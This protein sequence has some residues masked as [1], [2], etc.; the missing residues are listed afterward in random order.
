MRLPTDLCHL[1]LTNKSDKTNSHILSKFISTKFMEG[2]G[3]QRRGYQLDTE[4]VLNNKSKIIQ[5]SVK[6]DY[7]L[8]AEC[9]AYFGLIENI[10][11]RTF[12][13]LE[14]G[15]AEGKILKDTVKDFLDLLYC[16]NS[17]PIIIRLFVYSLFWR[18][19]ISNDSLFEDYQLKDTFE[20]EVRTSLLQYKAR[21]KDEL[22]GLT[23]SDHAIQIFP[24]TIM[25]AKSFLDTTS[26]ILFAP[27]SY[28]PYCLIVDRFSFMLFRRHDD[29]KVDFIR[30]FSNT[31]INDCRIMMVS[32]ELWQSLMVTKPFEKIIENAKTIEAKKNNHRQQ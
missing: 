5:D 31:Q 3:S 27:Y 10:A 21:T 24:F 12:L 23:N 17:N 11:S 13:N 16:I 2:N 7:I 6:E 32:Q 20:D 8:C 4:T 19:S 18:V 14:K 15:I 9:E 30:E 28:D 29:I 25:T 26:N 22:I 1:C